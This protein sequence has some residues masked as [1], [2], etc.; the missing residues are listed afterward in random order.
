M[1]KK[2][3]ILTF[4]GF[5]PTGGAGIQADIETIAALGGHC[6]PIITTQTIQNTQSFIEAQPIELDWLQ[7]Q[8]EHLLEDITPDAIKIGLVTDQ[9]IVEFIA[10]IIKK[11]PEIPVVFDPVLRSGNGTS[12]ACKD[13]IKTFRTELLP[14]TTILTPNQH[15]AKL[16]SRKDNLDDAATDLIKAGCKNILSTGTDTAT[17]QI[18]HHHYA[19]NGL[20]NSLTCKKIP[21]TFHGSGCTLSSAI[22]INLAQGLSVKT[23][24]EQAHEF[25]LR[26]IKS[27]HQM[28]KEQKH[29]NRI[30]TTMKTDQK[31]RCL[32]TS[33]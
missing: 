24:I 33:F 22:T 16:L 14:L 13:L 8:T 7:K 5:D 32:S 4:A 29:L 10:T 17:D 26:A 27:G 3:I 20:I 25:T 21:G 30:I 12:L 2:K 28:G 18:E 15:E 6:C 31:K 19:Q 23:A 1:T 9:K 11:F